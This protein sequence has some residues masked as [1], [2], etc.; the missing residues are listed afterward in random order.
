[1]RPS[2]S[3]AFS[4]LASIL[5]MHVSTASA[6]NLPKNAKP[7]SA[8][9][10]RSVYSGKS[11]VWDTSN[12][13]FFAP[14][15]TVIGYNLKA[16]VTFT[17]SWAVSSNRNCMNIIWKKIKSGDSGKVS[18]CWEWYKDGKKIW[19]LWSTRYD[20]SKPKKGDYYQ[21]EAKILKAGDKVSG[22][23]AKLTKS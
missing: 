1:M 6:D 14:D 2:H 13:A 9:E 18:D 22:E 11:A 7:M 12:R 20:G 15:G 21:G 16:K 10:V 17:G 19:T 8:D 23:Y 3:T 4:I 5:T